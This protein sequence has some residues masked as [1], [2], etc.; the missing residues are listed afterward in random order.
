MSLARLN[1]YLWP[2]ERTE[3][4]FHLSLCVYRKNLHLF[5]I[6]CF[7]FYCIP[8]TIY[9]FMVGQVG[10]IDHFF[11]F[12]NWG[13]FACTAYFGLASWLEL[14]TPVDA[15]PKQGFLWKF[16]HILFELAFAMEFTIALFFW[17]VLA[18]QYFP[19]IV[20]EPDFGAILLMNILMHAVTP[21]AMWIELSLNYIEFHWRHCLV[22]L[23][24]VSLVY[25][26]VNAL[27]V[28]VFNIS[29]YQPVID[30]KSWKTLLMIVVALILGFGGFG[31]GYW[32]HK[33]KSR[34]FE[35]KRL[36]ITDTNEEALDPSF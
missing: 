8:S 5:R 30:W 7:L 27:G 13:H 10:F 28:L 20:D 24:L 4:Q 36:L 3:Y 2:E 25:D 32:I 31:V 34:R 29:I 12:T 11:F 16:T 17:A 15:P 22:F 21:L 35:R 33:V 19:T 14:K 18:P 9:M 6:L 1:D 23:P 26:I